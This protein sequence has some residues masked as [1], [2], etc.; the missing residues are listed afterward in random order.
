VISGEF[1]V[2]IS[3]VEAWSV[4]VEAAGFPKKF[5]NLKVP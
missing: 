1:T 2:S 5:V 4:A 3:M